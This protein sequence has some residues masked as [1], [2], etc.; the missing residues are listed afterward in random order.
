MGCC[1]T[2]SPSK[3]PQKEAE[4]T[5]S[6][7][8]EEIEKKMEEGY[9]T[10]EPKVSND[11]TTTADDTSAANNETA[12][13]KAPYTMHA[14]AHGPQRHQYQPKPR[15]GTPQ[16]G[17][18]FE[19]EFKFKTEEQIKREGAAIQRE[20]DQAFASMPMVALQSRVPS[21]RMPGMMI[22]P[23]SHMRSMRGRNAQQF[24]GQLGQM[25]GSSFGQPSIGGLGARQPQI[26]GFYYK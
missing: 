9:S 22:N 23:H 5:Q 6:N 21:M 26:G 19:M 10:T 18:K 24:S 11:I 3:S 2:K 25:G 4:V 1:T 7:H 15:F 12:T 17:N 14:L 16:L 13:M 8:N 20:V